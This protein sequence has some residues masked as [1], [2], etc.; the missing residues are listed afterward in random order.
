MGIVCDKYKQLK[1]ELHYLCDEAVLAQAWKKSH[2]YIRSHNWYADTLELDCSAMNLEERIKEW[3]KQLREQTYSPSFMRMVPAPKTDQWTFYQP[4]KCHDWKWGPKPIDGKSKCK[5][6][7][8][9]AHLSI[10]DQTI[11][12]AIM[13]CLADAVETEQGSTD[14]EKDHNVWSY[15]NRLFCDWKAK[16]AQFRWGNSNTYS[17]YFQDYQRFLERPVK[18]LQNLQQT[19]PSKHGIFEI[20]LD[21]SAFYDSIDRDQLVFELKTI[22]R[23]H[24]EVDQAQ[25]DKFWD[26]AGGI[27]QGWKWY[28][29]DKNLVSCLKN[30]TLKDAHGLPQGMV[31]SGFFANAYL[32]SL[33]QRIKEKLGNDLNGVTLIDYCRYV[34]DL[35]LLVHASIKKEPKWKF[36]IKTEIQELIE[37]TKGIELNSDKT[38]IERHTAKRSG[39]SVRMK[40]IQHAASGPQDMMA[41]DDMQGSL[42]GLFALAEQSLG[43]RDLP[44]RDCPIP[45]A[46]IDNPQMDVREDTLLRFTANRIT[47]ALS[48]KRLFVANENT[49]NE[50]VS[51]LDHVHEVFA[52]RFVAAWTRNPSL[53]SILKKGIQLY[54][55][56]DLLQP[57]FESLNKKMGPSICDPNHDHD[58]DHERLIAAYCLAEI[59]RFAALNLHRQKP[60][61]R[62][63]HS[64]WDKL[65]DFLIDRAGVLLARVS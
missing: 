44:H 62:P 10:Q 50:N 43:Q 63:Q 12:T 27:I 11:A 61:E 41:L 15:G 60:E 30:E 13:L 53:V 39:V 35:R 49:D 26:V 2:S 54:P 38:K 22:A 40:A 3:A 58:H 25:S 32:I 24:Y 48:K 29:G 31:A 59:Y 65:R 8:P 21:L 57:V 9:L 47:T 1:P 20:H 33:D 52:H 18:K 46:K 37:Q 23:K 51:E 17:K 19:L 34:D 7:R 45:L 56:P 5:E 36:W 16:R 28:E 14:P 64:N 6:L 4:E 42:E 55:H